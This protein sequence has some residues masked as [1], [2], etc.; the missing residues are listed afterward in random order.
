[1]PRPR[2]RTRAGCWRCSPCRSR[3]GRS[4]TCCGRGS[5]AWGSVPPHR[6]CG[7]RR[8][9]L[10]D[11]TR[12]TLRRLRLDPYVDLFRGEHLGFSPTVESV[13]R[14]WDLAAIAKEHETF[15]DGHERVLHAWRQRPD[16]PPEEAYRDY[17]LA[18]D[19]WRHLPYTDPGLPARLLPEDWPGTRS[20]AVFRGLHARLR[21]AGAQ[22]AG[23]TPHAP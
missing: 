11:E 12:H 22:F 15:L 1:M 5:R 18:L 16:T 2:R 8:L 21:D 14:W 19:S 10:Y 17:L 20:A 7:S 6:G 23:V 13:A 9:P 3:S 4:A